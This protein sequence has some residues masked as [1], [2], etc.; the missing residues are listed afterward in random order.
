MI[1]NTGSPPI[2]FEKKYNSENLYCDTIGL[3]NT[4]IQTEV[5]AG[6]AELT[7]D[8]LLPKTLFVVKFDHIDK[9]II[10]GYYES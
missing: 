7:A 8:D 5:F 10:S 6:I 1:R 3:S 9:I 2:T 4:S